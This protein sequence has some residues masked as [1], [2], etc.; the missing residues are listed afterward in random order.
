MSA[1]RCP[2]CGDQAMPYRRYAFHLKSHATC[3]SCGRTVRVRG[4]YL[5]LVIAVLLTAAIIL[6][7]E[8]F[9]L[10]A[11]RHVA[12]LAAL[13]IIGLVL[14]YSAWRWLGFG[15]SAEPADSGETGAPTSS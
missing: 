8:T 5:L 4:F 12:A 14:D 9:D 2:Y 11:G 1:A 10:G 6:L 3:A 13:A 7:F 15:P